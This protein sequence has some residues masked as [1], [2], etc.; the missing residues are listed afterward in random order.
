MPNQV[1]VFLAKLI[2][3]TK[4]AAYGMN[5]VSGGASTFILLL[6][7]MSLY[8]LIGIK[9]DSIGKSIPKVVYAMLPCMSFFGPLIHSNGSMIR[10]TLYFFIYM[11]YLIPCAT[12]DI[13]AKKQFNAVLGLLALVLIFLTLQGGYIP[14]YFYWDVD[15]DYIW[16]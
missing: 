14:Y 10:I 15:S 3:S 5:E 4:Y 12:K 13:V 6:E 11:T 8:T 16:K 1:I 2:G 7:L 9:T